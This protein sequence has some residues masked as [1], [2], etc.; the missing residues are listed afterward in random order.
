MYSLFNILLVTIIIR[1][2][3]MNSDQQSSDYNNYVHDKQ[4][5]ITFNDPIKQDLK[6]FS[7]NPA[8]SAR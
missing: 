4:Q 2:R 3:G 6:R 1:M 7:K 5:Q 8:T